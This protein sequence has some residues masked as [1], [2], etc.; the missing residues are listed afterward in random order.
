MSAARNRLAPVGYVIECRGAWLRAQIR[1]VASVITVTGRLDQTNVEPMIGHLC[2]FTTLDSPVIIDVK[3]VDIEDNSSALERL[4][5]TFS[6]QCRHRGIDWALV[7]EPPSHRCALPADDRH[8]L[9]V[10]SVADALHHFVRVI[11]ARPRTPVREGR[12]SI[13]SAQ[14]VE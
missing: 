12:G 6:A 3:H 10:D 5:S 14:Y 1:S 4:V 7:A 2:R 13:G 9:C 8:L 11:H